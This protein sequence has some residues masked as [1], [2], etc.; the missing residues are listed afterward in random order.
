MA[1]SFPVSAHD[2]GHG[3]NLAM[4]RQGKLPACSF[5]DLM[6][7]SASGLSAAASGCHLTGP[8]MP[9]RMPPFS[10][11]INARHDVAML[12]NTRQ[13]GT[14]LSSYG[15]KAARKPNDLISRPGTRRISTKNGLIRHEGGSKAPPEFQFLGKFSSILKIGRD[16]S[17]FRRGLGWKGM[18]ALFALDG[19]ARYPVLAD[20]VAQWER[21]GLPWGERPRA[22]NPP[23]T[24]VS[25]G[26]S[27]AQ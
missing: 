4:E 19:R 16:I 15:M 6:S 24:P 26:D 14:C 25:R 5:R 1:A 12:R 11:I 27:C 22:L 10:Y 3:C 21:C 2:S 9:G 18:K 23:P 20:V 13:E 8:G 17:L 7:G